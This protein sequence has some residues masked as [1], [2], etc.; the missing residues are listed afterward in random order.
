MAQADKDKK[1][2]VDL[3]PLNPDDMEAVAD[4]HGY[5][6]EETAIY[7]KHYFG[8]G[9]E[10]VSVED[11]WGLVCSG[12]DKEIF[13]ICSDNREPKQK[14]HRFGSDHSYIMGALRNGNYS[15]VKMLMTF[16]QKILDHESSE[17]LIELLK[18][19]GIQ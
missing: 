2:G 14:Y 17:V 19:K 3:D 4:E 1:A 16:G 7:K 13:K 18:A 11:F 6:E 8:E 10:E 15:T 9:V 5:D 12:K